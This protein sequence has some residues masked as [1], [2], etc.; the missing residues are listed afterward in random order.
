M[1]KTCG[2]CYLGFDKMP[3]VPKPFGNKWNSQKLQLTEHSFLPGKEQMIR[4]A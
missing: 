2:S 3:F 1:A 4:I